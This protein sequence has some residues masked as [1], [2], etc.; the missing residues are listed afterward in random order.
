MN[1]VIDRLP[2]SVLIDGAAV[3]INTDFRVCLRILKAFD[4]ERLTEHEKLTV[5]ISLLYPEYPSNTALAVKQG[6]KFL[7]RGS[8]LN[9]ANAKQL[10]VYSF[11]KDSSYIYSAFKSTFNIDL[12]TVEYLHWWSFRSLFADLGKD[13]FFNTLVSLRSRKSSGKLTKE[14]KEFVAKNNELIELKERKKSSAA[15]EFISRIGRRS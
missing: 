4:D 15:Q 13:C 1:M 8:E 6:L 11:E 3:K 7:N 9:D 5:L 12:S 14:E 2:T 10:Q